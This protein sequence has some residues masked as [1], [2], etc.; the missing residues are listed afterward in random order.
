MMEQL[1]AAV[2]PLLALSSWVAT[3]AFLATN[4]A[5]P[6]AWW[7]IVAAISTFY[8]VQRRDEKREEREKKG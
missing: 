3:I 2:R 7:A 4:V 1:R 8:F 6:E 5:I